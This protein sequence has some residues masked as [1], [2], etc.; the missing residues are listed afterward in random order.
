MS[1]DIGQ[2]IPDIIDK[3]VMQPILVHPGPGT[4]SSVKRIE[5]QSNCGL[6]AYIS[7]GPF[8]RHKNITGSNKSVHGTVLNGW[9]FL[10][11]MVTIRAEIIPKIT[12]CFD[13]SSVKEICFIKL[14]IGRLH[15]HGTRASEEMVSGRMT[16]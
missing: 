1:D 3:T 10:A 4:K 14:R 13:L 2:I 8:L 12:S 6:A 16:D 9:P 5:I 15:F 7:M 11:D